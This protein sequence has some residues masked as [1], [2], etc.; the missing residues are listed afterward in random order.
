MT[1]DGND[2]VARLQMPEDSCY[3]RAGVS[4]SLPETITC[5]SPMIGR[6]AGLF[7]VTGSQQLNG[8]SEISIYG[9]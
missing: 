6:Y 9:Y 4:P 2:P 1:A 3:Y 5:G 7:W 8:L